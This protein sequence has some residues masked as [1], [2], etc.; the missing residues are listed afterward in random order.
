MHVDTGINRLGVTVDEAVAIA[1]RIQSENHGITLLMSQLACGDEL[2]SPR[3]VV[4]CEFVHTRP[5][6]D[7]G[8]GLP[9]DVGL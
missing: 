5:N 4:P 8:A 9:A 6:N 7:F 1:S 3:E 2:G